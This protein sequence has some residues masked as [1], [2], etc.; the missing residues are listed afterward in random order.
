[1][2][3]TVLVFC[4]LSLSTL[5]AVKAGEKPFFETRAIFQSDGAGFKVNAYPV[6]ACLPDGRLFLAWCASDGNKFRI[7]GAFSKDA[8]KNWGAP[9][10]LINTEGFVDGDANIILAGEEIQVYSSSRRLGAKEFLFSEIWKTTRKPGS[11]AWKKPE[12][13][14]MHRRYIVGKVHIGLTLPDGTLLMPY[15][16]DIPAE[17]GH[18]AATGREMNLRSGALLSRDQGNTWMPSQDMYADAPR[19]SEFAAGG[20]NEPAMVLLPNGEVFALLRTP[21][22]WLYE[23]R[24]SDGGK[25][26]ATP[27]PSA[28]QAHNAPAALC[29]LKGLP[30]VL[31]VWNNS[32]R[33]RWPLEVAISQDG[34]R[35]WSKPRTLANTPGFQSSYPAPTQAADGTLIA[36]WG[37][38]RADKKGVDLHIARFNRSWVLGE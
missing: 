24:S 26:W 8:G 17:E 21:D 30:D 27:R 36:V 29:R 7:V 22:V 19:A 13:V 38:E 14:P 16:W 12:R 35:N 3:V 4:V 20:V 37:S 31:V 23:S 1:M 2:R 10:E 18:P 25:T 32:P 11:S 5:F 6:V 33:N 15:S 28:L 9:E 34:C